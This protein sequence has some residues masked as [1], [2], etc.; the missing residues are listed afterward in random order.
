[1]FLITI[2][3][4]GEKMKKMILTLLLISLS[5]IAQNRPVAGE[6]Y[7]LTYN[8]S[9]RDIFSKESKLTLVY[10]FDFWGTGKSYASGP[11]GLFQNVLNPDE[12]RKLETTMDFVDGKFTAR[13]M[14]PESAQLLSYYITDSNNFDYNDKKT[15]VSYVYDKSGYPVKGARFRNVDF[16]LMAGAETDIIIKELEDE[17]AAF[18]ED[19]LVRSVLWEKRFLSKNNLDDIL[20]LRAEFEKEFSNLK[21]DAQDNYDLLNAE[22]RIY[23]SFQSALSS[24]VMPYYQESN[25]KIIEI[26]SQ[27]PD[28]KRSSVVERIYQAH[29]QQQRSAKF[30]EEVIGKPLIDFDFIALN[31][32]TKKLS[33]YKGKVILL[34][35]WGTWCGPCVAEIPNLI[36][37][38]NKYKSFGFEIISISSDLMMNT[39]NE[40][41]F[42]LFI[43]QKSMDWT[44]TLDDKNQ[45]IHRLY[46][47]SHWPTLYLID[48]TGRIVKNE[49]EL[50]GEL[51]E[52]TLEMVLSTK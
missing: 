2:T 49:N 6:A 32:E 12:G 35:F 34:D 13:I 21:K 50:R 51:L 3:K 36:K 29:L 27:I 43:E 5:A 15:F 33:D 48:Q 44:H 18:P 11:K 19:Y 7:P 47:I 14:I 10:V 8:L 23:T 39:K 25:N 31:G 24:F 1:L 4:R 17:L 26:A 28:G 16:L 46:E 20:S 42:K 30:T 22:A 40:E 37:V 9:D 52:K 45:T 38:Y 41:D